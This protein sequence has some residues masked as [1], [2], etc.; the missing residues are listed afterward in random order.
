MADRRSHLD[1]PFYRP[2]SRRIA[3]V[4]VT[5]VWAAA[6]LLADPAS[7]WTVMAL[8]VFAY[9]A[10]TFLIAWRDRPPPEA[11]GGT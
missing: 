7:V 11:G 4:V 1:H 8:A 6:E 10:W 2:R 9:A 5:A 3:I